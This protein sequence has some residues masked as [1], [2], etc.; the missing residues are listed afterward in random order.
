[1]ITQLYFW[2]NGNDFTSFIF[3]VTLFLTTKNKSKSLVVIITL[4]KRMKH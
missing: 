1:M 4:E 3:I 2:G